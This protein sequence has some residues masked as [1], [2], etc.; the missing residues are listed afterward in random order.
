L[1]VTAMVSEICTTPAFS[2]MP[3]SIRVLGGAFSPN[4]RR[5]TLLDL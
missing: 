3:A 2:P 4:W 1:K 5:C